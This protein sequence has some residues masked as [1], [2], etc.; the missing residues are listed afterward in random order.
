MIF[1]TCLYFDIACLVMTNSQYILLCEIF[2][3]VSVMTNIRNVPTILVLAI[4][5][6]KCEHGEHSLKW[7]GPYSRTSYD[8]S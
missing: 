1:C 8:L 7:S 6:L 3:D 2:I 5:A 4:A